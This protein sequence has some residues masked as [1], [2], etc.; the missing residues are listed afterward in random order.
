MRDHHKDHVIG[1]CFL[2]SL[3]HYL[4]EGVLGRLDAERLSNKD[5]DGEHE[6]P[7]QDGN[8]VGTIPHQEVA[9]FVVTFLIREG[10]VAKDAYKAV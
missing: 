10:E 6:Q 8:V 1:L 3:H 9:F 7:Y 5:S 4:E 2:P